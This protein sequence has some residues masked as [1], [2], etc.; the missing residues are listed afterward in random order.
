MTTDLT[1][2]RLPPDTSLDDPLAPAKGLRHASSRSQELLLTLLGDY[3]FGRETYI[4]SA[5]LVAL[6]GSFGITEQAARAVLSRAS[7]NGTLICKRQSRHTSY[8]MAPRGVRL[9]LLSGR[10]ILRFAR[11]RPERLRPWDGTWTLISYSLATD[12]A[13]A[14]RRIRRF[15]RNRGFAPLQDGLWVSPHRLREEV[16]A[17]LRAFDVSA[18]NLFE[19]AQL[20]QSSEANPANLWPLAEVAS[21]YQSLIEDFQ[22]TTRRLRR[23]LPE[24]PDAL[25]LRTEAMTAWR[26]IPTVDPNL[27]LELLPRK[28]PGWRARE[29]FTEIYDNLGE[30]AAA[31]VRNVVSQY[32]EEAAEAVRFDTVANPRL[33]T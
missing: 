18:F 21:R 7:R 24:G 29:L 2:P 33:E 32:S 4:P 30:P 28:W 25:T 16:P 10:V 13:E 3:W 6:L 1:P 14:R 5:A 15:L 27:P 9:T 8:R 19:H 26:P 22:K 17:T 20:S 31:H 11:Q 23:K 12:Q